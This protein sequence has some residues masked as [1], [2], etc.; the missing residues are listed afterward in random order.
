MQGHKHFSGF[1]EVVLKNIE[2]VKEISNMVKKS[3]GPNG[4]HHL[5]VGW[6]AMSGDCDGAGQ[7]ISNFFKCPFLNGRHEED[8]RQPHRQ[9]LRYERRS[10]HPERVGGAASRRQDGGHGQ[11]D[12]VGG[13]WRRHQLRHYL[14]RG[15]L[16]SCR[17]SHQYRSASQSDHCRL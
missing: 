14:R 10:H 5:S 13:M 11:Q 8:D 16:E 17:K 3:L 7:G 4:K 9:D 2:N 15:A 1:E 6:G 12:A